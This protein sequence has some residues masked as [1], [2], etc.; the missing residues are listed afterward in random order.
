MFQQQEFYEH[1]F[2]FMNVGFFLVTSFA[3]PLARDVPDRYRAQA[4][5]GTSEGE[6]HLGTKCGCAEPRGG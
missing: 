4:P 1:Q 6:Q 3:G 5:Y 2:M